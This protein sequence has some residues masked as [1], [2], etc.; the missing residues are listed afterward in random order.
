VR[1]VWTIDGGRVAGRCGPQ[2]APWDLRAL[3]RAGFTA[4]VSLECNDP[5]IES[6]SSRG[7]RHLKLCV[8]DFA[9]PTQDQIDTFNAFVD[10]EQE[11]IDDIQAA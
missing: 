7:L 9:A 3:R 11:F 1:H 2:K 5:G 10:R 8:E 6:V 4:I